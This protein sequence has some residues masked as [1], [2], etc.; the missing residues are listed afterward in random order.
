MQP[1]VRHPWPFFLLDLGYLDFLN[2]Q[3]KVRPHVQDALAA[4]V[5][6]WQC[7]EW[8][9]DHCYWNKKKFREI[10]RYL[11]YKL[12]IYKKKISEIN[13]YLV[14]RLLLSNE[15]LGAGWPRA[16]LSMA[17]TS[18]SVASVHDKA[19]LEAAEAICSNSLRVISAILRS[20]SSFILA[21]SSSLKNENFFSEI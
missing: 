3:A 11:N 17:S 19:S 21:S 14:W 6:L 12:H 7:M 18:S 5:R 16:I 1:D 10:N 13:T 15:R 9:E 4:I 2:L 8:S 20:S